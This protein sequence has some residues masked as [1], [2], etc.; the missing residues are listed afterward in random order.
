MVRHEL[1]DKRLICTRCIERGDLFQRLPCGHMGVAGMT[2]YS[3]SADGSNFQC[4]R[5]TQMMGLCQQTC[6]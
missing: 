1:P 6:T 2:V 5:C 4:G 3:D